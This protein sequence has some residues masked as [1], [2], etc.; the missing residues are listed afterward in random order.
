MEARIVAKIKGEFVAADATGKRILV[1]MDDGYVHIVGQ[2]RLDEPNIQPRSMH[3]TPDGKYAVSIT[4]RDYRVHIWD[5]ETA[6]QVGSFTE[7]FA[8]KVRI[9]PDGKYV[10][11]LSDTLGIWHNGVLRRLWG[12]PY[13]ID[14]FVLDGH[15]IV[16]CTDTGIIMRYEVQ[17]GTMVSKIS[18]LMFAPDRFFINGPYIMA[19]I[20]RDH[21]YVVIKNNEIIHRIRAEGD[22][23]AS[24]TNENHV[25]FVLGTRIEV[26]N[27]R[28]GCMDATWR[29]AQRITDVFASTEYVITFDVFYQLR[30]WDI[31]TG[32][33]LYSNNKL[34]YPWDI[35]MLENNR[36]LIRF[37]GCSI[38]VLQLW[39]RSAAVAAFTRGMADGDRRIFSSILHTLKC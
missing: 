34:G 39:D 10:V 19:N 8:S 33:L 28:T 25:V 26:W 27:F 7:T 32:K 6:Q 29:N 15:F 17:T 1:H 35:R 16:V 30:I 38:I 18:C 5:L 24:Y 31:L 13:R 23:D 37:P 20:S 36:L 22:I 12:R 3:M 21:H 2:G 4:H 11:V 9:T 14:N